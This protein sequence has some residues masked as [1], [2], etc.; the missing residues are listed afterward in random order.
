M[1]KIKLTNWNKGRNQ[2]TFRPLVM[3][4]QEF[5]QVGI[6]FVEDGS[7]DIEFVGMAD[8]LNKRISLEQS[9]E[10]G[11]ANLQSKTGEYYLF[12]GS[13]STS[14]M[15]A[16]EVFSQSS[17]KFLFKTALTTQEQYKQPSAFNKWFFGQDSDLNLSYDIPDDIFSRIKLC[18]WNHGYHHH[19]YQV[20]SYLN[21]SDSNYTR[22]V[23]LCAIYQGVHVEN[24]DHLVRNDLCYT[25]H[26]T[27]AWDILKKT[28]G[29]VYEIDKRPYPDFINVMQRSKASLSPF[30]MGEICFRDFEI[31]QFGSV[32]IKPDMGLVR[33]EPNIYI[34]YETYIPC[35]L[36]YSDLPE[37]IQWVKDNP[38][39][40]KRIVETARKIMKQS[41][42]IENLVLYWY[43][44]L[45]NVSPTVTHE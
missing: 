26:R 44:M 4:A 8:F 28:Q 16:Y 37:K 42:S 14:L 9:I 10:E 6:V 27:T 22:D 23:D 20:G 17:A 15:A 7:Y 2:N 29:I 11:L 18:G 25:K 19:L 34:P 21:F 40:C 45:L 38:E 35:K 32:M 1:I 3:Y 30:G 33:T 12:D 5:A 24:T 13:D 41:Y 31:I 39:E 36:D 43:N